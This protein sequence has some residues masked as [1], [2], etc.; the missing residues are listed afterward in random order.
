M[1]TRDNWSYELTGS[2][3]FYTDNDDF[4]GG[5]KR[6]QEPL[7]AIQSHL[8]YRFPKGKWASFSAG[9]GIGGLSKV[10]GI[11][12]ND[13]RHTL[14]SA[15]SFGMPIA[16]TQSIKVAYLYGQTNSNTGF[17]SDSFLVA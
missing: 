9:Y 3:F 6:E 15:L 16:R 14:L 10:N 5:Q 4:F 13:K 2:V 12:K 11:N 17:D 8:I 7:Y 1:H